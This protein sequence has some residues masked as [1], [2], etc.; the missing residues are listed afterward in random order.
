MT[1]GLSGL[2]AP[3]GGRRRAG[4][5]TGS[6]VGR[7]IGLA[8]AG[9]VT[10]LLLVEVIGRLGLA[11]PSWPPLS[12]VLSYLTTPTGQLVL[13]RAVA[14]SGTAAALGFLLGTVLGVILAT[15]GVLLPPVGPGLDRLAA[16]LHAIPLIALGPLL[17]N[18]VGRGATPTLVAALAAGFA[19]FVAA[20]SA[21]GAAGE[22]Q[23]DVFAVLGASRWR[24]LLRLQLPAGLPLIVDGLTLAAPAAVLGAVIG[25]WFGAPRGVGVLL[26]SAM[27]NFQ[28][29]LLWAA[30]LSA[31]VLA[32]A[33]YLALIGLRR[34]VTRRF[35]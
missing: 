33:G 2:P 7:G 14:A 35:T 18:T 4:A 3:T 21:L 23:R 11:G 22:G 29:N 12:A 31:S 9:V 13:G 16:V 34:L 27:Q 5:E 32:L 26:V 8:V 30:A 15:L 10:L 20:T 25:E 19:V 17:I 24:T 6:D 1:S 28:P